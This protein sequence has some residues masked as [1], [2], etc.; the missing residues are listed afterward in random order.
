MERRDRLR[1]V[2]IP[3]SLVTAVERHDIPLHEVHAE[4]AGRVKRRRICTVCGREVPYSDVARGYED[5]AGHRVTLTDDDLAD[6][7]LPSK[8]LI[9]VLVFV[10]EHTIDPLRLAAIT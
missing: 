5:H 7:P 10:D 9:D 3:V 4:D 1:L 2:S 8:R 6:L